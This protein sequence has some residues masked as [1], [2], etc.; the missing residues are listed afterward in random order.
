MYQV[1]DATRRA[2][3]IARDV[4]LPRAQHGTF[5]F[6]DDDGDEGAAYESASRHQS[7]GSTALY[8]VPRETQLADRKA[9]G[10]VMPRT[11]SNSHGGLTNTKNSNSNSN[12]ASVKSNTASSAR[13]AEESIKI[14]G[15]GRPGDF[16]DQPEYLEPAHVV[17]ADGAEGHLYQLPS[18]TVPP[19]PPVRQASFSQQPKALSHSQQHGDD[20]EMEGHLYQLPDDSAVGRKDSTY[21]EPVPL[22]DS[23]N[24]MYS[25]LTPA[26]PSRSSIK[27][28]PS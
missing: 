2:D 19:M 10:V 11:L 13:H 3:S 22:V 27:G 26:P 5:G 18:D 7:Q 28:K 9:V 8:E 14:Y 24:M 25:T 20:D 6:D 21:L 12:K 1:P 23:A 4:Q 15:S 16:D 17:D